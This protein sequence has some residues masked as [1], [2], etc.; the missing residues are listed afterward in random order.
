MDADNKALMKS[1]RDET[2]AEDQLYEPFST[3]C[4][5]ISVKI[6]VKKFEGERDG[7][8]K[9]HEAMM[10]VVGGRELGAKRV[11]SRIPITA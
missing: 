2:V 4:T 7:K 11:A 3:F 8:T 6:V 9:G 1:L 5:N 10:V